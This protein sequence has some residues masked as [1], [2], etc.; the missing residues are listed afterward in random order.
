LSK[1]D[2]FV[3]QRNQIPV[4]DNGVTLFMSA[5]LPAADSLGTKIVSVFPKNLKRGLPTI[6]AVVIALN[7]ETGQPEAVMDG[8]YLTAMRTGAASGV[9]TELLAR[10]EAENVC[11][12]GAG[13]QGRT[14]LEA[15]CCVRDIKKVFVYDLN[16]KAADEYIKEMKSKGAPL[17]DDFEK[18]VSP[19]EALRKSDI[20]CTAT[21]SLTPVFDDSDL[22]PGIHINGVGSYRPDMQEIPEATIIRSRVFV[23]SY[24]AS[25]AETGDLIIPFNKGMITEEHI[26]TEIGQVAAGEVDG[27][28]SEEEMTFFKSV[29]VAVQDVSVSKIIVANAKK[30]GIGKEMEL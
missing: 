5:Y 1:G 15:V 23:D 16:P 24:K 6:H 8:T 11:I 25:M 21:T 26:K 7:I 3:P 9:A 10:K 2:T 28:K 22:K 19:M 18:V 14:Q 4:K 13:V 27:R 29:G 30:Q 20:I 12:I 17:P